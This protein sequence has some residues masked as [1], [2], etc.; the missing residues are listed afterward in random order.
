MQDFRRPWPLPKASLPPIA[1]DDIASAR[2]APTE[3]ALPDTVRAAGGRLFFEPAGSRYFADG[4]SLQ[5]RR[6]DSHDRK[7]RTGKVSKR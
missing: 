7:F 1:S 6:C 2:A 4:G 3:G 5:K